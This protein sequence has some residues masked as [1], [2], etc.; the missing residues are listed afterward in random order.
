MSKAT[1][2]PATPKP[3]PT[4]AFGDGKVSRPTPDTSERTY[5]KTERDR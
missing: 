3:Q 2:T 5:P 4:V 1:P